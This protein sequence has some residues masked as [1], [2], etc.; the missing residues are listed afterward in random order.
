MFVHPR[1]TLEPGHK[2][3]HADSCMPGL[4]FRRG[5]TLRMRV[6][7]AQGHSSTGTRSSRYEFVHPRATLQPGHKAQD[8]CSCT[9]GLLYRRGTR[10]RMRVCEIQEYSSNRTRGSRYEF[11]HT[12][13]TLQPK[14]G[15]QKASRSKT[16]WLG[17]RM[18]DIH[19][20]PGAKKGYTFVAHDRHPGGS[21]SKTGSSEAA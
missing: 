15:V 1:T 17:G 14:H 8:V 11:V 20:A 6:C 9:P 21:R 16:A 5:T 2:T 7:A 3:Q 19:R 12:W 18:M 10:L 4:L 13:A